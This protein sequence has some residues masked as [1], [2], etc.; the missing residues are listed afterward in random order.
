MHMLYVYFQLQEKR[1]KSL[2]SSQAD[3]QSCVEA[4]LVV[5]WVCQLCK[6]Y[7]V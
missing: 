6:N 5:L 3:I 4:A 2:V 7:P 1:K